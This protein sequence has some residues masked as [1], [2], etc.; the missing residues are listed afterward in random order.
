MIPLPIRVGEGGHREVSVMDESV[1][2]PGMDMEDYLRKRALQIRDLEERKL[3]RAVGET[4]LL[5][6]YRHTRRE[7]M[8]L[9][10]RVFD[11]TEST[12]HQ[13]PIFIGVTDLAH[14]DATDPFLHPLLPEDAEPRQHKMQDILECL[15]EG[16]PYPLYTVFLEADHQTVSAFS[17]E[18]KVYHCTVL[19][20]RGEYR[21]Q[22][23]VR[24]Q[25]AYHARIEELYHIF[26]ANFLPWSTVCTAY[27]HK[28][29]E[30]TLTSV[31][32]MAPEDDILEIRVDFG[33]Y[34]PFIRHDHFP[35]WNLWPMEEKTSTYPEPCVDKIN[36]EHRI[37]AHR[38]RPECQYLMADPE[39]EVTNIRRLDGDLI[40]TCPEEAPQPWHLYRVEPPNSRSC[41]V[42]QVL[43][44]LSRQSFAGDLS[45]RYR[46]GIRT[47]GEITRVLSSYGYDSYARFQDAVLE[48]LRGEPPSTYSMDG[49]LLDELRARQRGGMSLTLFFSSPRPEHFLTT[50]IMSFLVTQIQGLFP[51]YLCQGRLI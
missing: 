28:F 43:S 48:P 38:L 24:P 11:E 32:G 42:Y 10:R 30:V 15:N 3:F 29:F 25:V 1:F 23:A 45:D 26:I 46:R 34:Q 21:A 13:F 16:H 6:L 9:E 31:E 5:E 20:Q 27:L 19:T 2:G 12:Q 41:S 44:N 49:F 50:D 40:F 18:G 8:D 36:Y 35:L 7:Y 39:V 14:Y 4:L 51:E 22:C 37:F 17:T 47:K 33:E